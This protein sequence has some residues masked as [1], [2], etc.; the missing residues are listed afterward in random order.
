MTNGKTL[1]VWKR[2]A[3]G[4]CIPS[5][6]N[7][8]ALEGSGWDVSSGELVWLREYAVEAEQA[9]DFVHQHDALAVVKM[10][11]ES[12]QANSSRH[13][14]RPISMCSVF[15][16]NSSPFVSARLGSKCMPRSGMAAI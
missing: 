9:H 8:A 5:A 10:D 14:S 2:A 4:R 11:V 15:L 3:H 1:S 12:T 16:L 13:P 7:I 6:A